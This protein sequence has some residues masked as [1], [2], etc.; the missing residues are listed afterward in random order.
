MNGPRHYHT[1]HV[2][3]V[4]HSVVSDSLQSYGLYVACQA[5]LSMG[6]PRQE[7]WSGLPFHSLEDLC[8]PVTKSGSPAFQAD[9]LPS[10]PPGK[11]HTKQSTQKEK[12]KYHII[13]PIG[14]F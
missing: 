11:P 8:N 2:F 13:S 6:F 4:S 10:E 14:G 9:Y 3:S 7:Y 1:K 12:G 5:P